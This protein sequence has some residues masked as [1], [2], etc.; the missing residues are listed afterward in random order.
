MCSIGTRLI[1]TLKVRGS[2]NFDNE[3]LQVNVIITL[4]SQS[5]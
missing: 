3:R 5:Q 1:A 4:I 2:T